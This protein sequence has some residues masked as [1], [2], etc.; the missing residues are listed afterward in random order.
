MSSRKQI[1]V[2]LTLILDKISQI[3]AIEEILNVHIKFSNRDIIACKEINYTTNLEERIVSHLKL[4]KNEEIIDKATCK[5]IKSV[6]SRPCIFL[7]VRKSGQEEQEWTTIFPSNLPTVGRTTYQLVKMLLPFL[8]PLTKIEYH[9][10][11]LL[12]FC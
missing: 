11:R 8:T 4:M 5:N 6:V 10:H 1:R 9:C 12:S 7:Q 2:T 3:S